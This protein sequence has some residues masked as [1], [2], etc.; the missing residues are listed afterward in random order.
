MKEV[1]Y[2]CTAGDV[3]CLRAG[4]VAGEAVRVL[5]TAEWNSSASVDERMNLVRATVDLILSGN[6]GVQ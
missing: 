2:E 1:G 4:H 3:A 5:A 6:L